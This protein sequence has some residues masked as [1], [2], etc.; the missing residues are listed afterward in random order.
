MGPIE[1]SVHHIYDVRL[2][3]PSVTGYWRG[4]HF[5]IRGHDPRGT[6]HEADGR[7]RHDRWAV[8]PGR[9]SLL[10]YTLCCYLCLEMALCH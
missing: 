7:E 4:H 8:V 10:I 5:D 9:I 1:D 2:Y 3:M 6:G